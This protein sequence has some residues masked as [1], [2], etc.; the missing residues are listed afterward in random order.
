MLC[1]NCKDKM[2]NIQSSRGDAHVSEQIERTEK[3]KNRSVQGCGQALVHLKQGTMYYA[4]NYEAIF[5]KK[6][7]AVSSKIGSGCL[8]VNFFSILYIT[9][10]QHASI[11]NT[12]FYRKKKTLHLPLPY[13]SAHQSSW[14]LLIQTF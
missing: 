2:K 10:H 5:K 7:Q 1:H 4:W 13:F 8:T 9:K 6:I 3:K 12:I 11:T 14:K